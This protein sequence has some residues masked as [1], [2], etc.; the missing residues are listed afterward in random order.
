MAVYGLEL[1]RYSYKAIETLE[2]KWQELENEVFAF[3][4]R[5]ERGE[6]DIAILMRLIAIFNQVK[7]V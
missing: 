1:R 7:L 5:A 3:V 6:C 2:I 4:S